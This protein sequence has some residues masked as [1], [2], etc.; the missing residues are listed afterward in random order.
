[1]TPEPEGPHSNPR[2][3]HRT[4]V[5]G[6]G[7]VGDPREPEGPL[8]GR[9][10][11]A[12]LASGDRPYHP[13]SP[14]PCMHHAQCG[15]YAAPWSQQ[16]RAWVPSLSGHLPLLGH[17]GGGGGGNQHN[18]QYAN[19]WAPLTRKRHIL[20]HPAQPRHTNHW[21][22]RTRKRHRQE[23]RPQ[24]PTERSDPTQHAKGRPGDCPGPRKET[25]TGRNVTHG[26][27]VQS[28]AAIID[29]CPATAPSYEGLL[30]RP[31]S[32][33]LHCVI[34]SLPSSSRR[35]GAT[36][37]TIPVP[38][39]PSKIHGPPSHVQSG[40]RT[41]GLRVSVVAFPSKSQRCPPPPPPRNGTG[42][43]PVSGTADPPE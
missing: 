35:R 16:H 33:R 3:Q 15:A 19:D 37:H 29:F 38:A 20:P 4:A 12:T 27:P 22:P 10:A 26:T 11:N 14:V 23:H 7:G 6:A 5:P 18:L 36:P 28:P 41:R 30:R 2:E 9:S 43:S 32:V 1:M 42:N 17:G 24:R 40:P 25:T 21:A 39:S 8:Q 13:P 34:A 31:T